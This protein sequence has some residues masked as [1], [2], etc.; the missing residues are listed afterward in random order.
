MDYTNNFNAG[1]FQNIYNPQVESQH[2]ETK[3]YPAMDQQQQNQNFNALVYQ[4]PNAFNTIEN[5]N[6]YSD[7]DSIDETPLV[8]NNITGMELYDTDPL[9]N[10]MI[11][12]DQ[13]LFQPTPNM[14]PNM[15]GGYDEPK[16]A[17]FNTNIVMQDP[18]NSLHSGMIE[19]SSAPTSVQ[20]P[21][22]V[23]HQ[24]SVQSHVIQQPQHV[25][26]HSNVIQ[27]NPNSSQGL[28]S[29]ANSS[30][31]PHIDPIP[32]R[33]FY[34]NSYNPAPP[35]GQT[36]TPVVPASNQAV[37][38]PED[39]LPVATNNIQET[40]NVANAQGISANANVTNTQGT[41][42]G[43]AVNVPAT[44]EH[45]DDEQ[46][47]VASVAEDGAET[48]GHDPLEDATTEQPTTNGVTQEGGEK[49][50]EEKKE[51]TKEELEKCVREG[52]ENV[53]VVNTEWEDEYCSNECCIKHCTSVFNAWV[54]ENLKASTGGVQNA[55]NT[56]M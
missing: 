18:M 49:E 15:F 39:T 40:T 19:T 23:I 41:A 21:S 31:T 11:N 4:Q 53:A 20:A 48:N 44:T 34:Q 22:N 13:N 45:M 26:S 28:H 6:L 46:E 35:A 10:S 14:Q 24:T 8:D 2:N 52:C 36:Y 1:S 54:Q 47:V 33:S 37:N 27:P 3:D 56:M 51:E 7:L 29:S 25:Q 16:L 17:H 38:K 43:N 32:A 50:D 9:D 12:Q 55:G 5:N 42:N 30:Q